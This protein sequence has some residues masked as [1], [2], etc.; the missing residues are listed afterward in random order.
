MGKVISLKLNKREERIVRRLNQEGITNS[1]L[2][3]SALWH[4]FEPVDY[5]ADSI[6]KSSYYDRSDISNGSLYSLKEEVSKLREN[7][8]KIQ[9]EFSRELDRLRGHLSQST[10]VT[11]LTKT[12]GLTPREQY[13]M[14]VHDNI[15]NVLKKKESSY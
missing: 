1:D 8:D 11:Q 10:P 9:E 13:V 3:R 6:K 14:D 2:L 7:H 15:D 5:S 4:Y 12:S